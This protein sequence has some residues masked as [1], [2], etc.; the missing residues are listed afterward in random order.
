MPGDVLSSAG[1]RRAEVSAAVAAAMAAFHVRMLACL[2]APRH[3]GSDNGGD[4]GGAA[5]ALRPAIYA[6]IRRWHAAAAEVCGAELAQLGLADVPA[7]VRVAPGWRQWT[8]VAST[9][10]K[11]SLACFPVGPARLLLSP[12]RASA[13]CSAPSGLALAINQL[14]LPR[15]A[16]HG[17]LCSWRSWRRSWRPD[18]HP[19]WGS[20]TTTCS[21]ETCCCSTPAAIAVAAAAVV[22][23][24]AMP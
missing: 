2:P 24:A 1:M 15:S 23:A 10:D 6:R 8:D 9:L 7:E 17:A 22:A 3:A 21:T 20:A 19:G 13:P 14:R 12:V 11:G 16:P 18:S 4:N 5:D